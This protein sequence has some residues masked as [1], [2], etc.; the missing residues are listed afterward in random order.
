MKKVMKRV[1]MVGL[2]SIAVMPAM[3]FA[4]EACEGIEEIISLVKKILTILQIG[5]PIVLLI[6]GTIDLG[7]AVMAGDEKEIKTATSTLL[8]RAIAAVAVFLLFTIVMIVTK[9]VGGTQWA[10]CWDSVS[11]EVNINTGLNKS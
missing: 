1:L 10:E 2:I 3:V 7:K 6:F 8:K 11:S 4:A 5:I 9:W